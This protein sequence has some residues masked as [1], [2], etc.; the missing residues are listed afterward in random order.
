M[1]LLFDRDRA[2][3]ARLLPEWLIG[4]DICEAA[5]YVLPLLTGL[6]T[7]HDDMVKEMFAPQLD[8]IMWHFFSVS[9]PC[10]GFLARL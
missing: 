10:A 2:R 8:R 1:R 7:D 5:E 4:V 3:V 6:A 9:C